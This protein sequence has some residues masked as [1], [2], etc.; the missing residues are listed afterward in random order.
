MLVK[1]FTNMQ[2]LLTYLRKF[3]VGENHQNQIFDLQSKLGGEVYEVWQV[4]NTIM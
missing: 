3:H 4:K 2:L 1:T